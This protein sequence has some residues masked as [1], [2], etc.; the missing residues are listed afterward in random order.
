MHR[1]IYWNTALI[2]NKRRVFDLRSLIQVG[3]QIM[4]SGRAREVTYVALHRRDAMPKNALVRF[5]LDAI[6]I[7][8]REGSRW[9]GYPPGELPDEAVLADDRDRLFLSG[10]NTSMN[11]NHRLPNYRVSSQGRVRSFYSVGRDLS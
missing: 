9:F 5:G 3:D 1:S 2:Y 7:R 6:E 11:H 4:V 8:T 10:F